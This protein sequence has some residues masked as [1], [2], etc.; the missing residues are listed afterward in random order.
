M[1]GARVC[2]CT[3]CVVVCVFVWRRYELSLAHADAVT[4]L[5][6]STTLPQRLRTIAANTLALTAFLESH[7]L[8]RTQPTALLHLMSVGSSAHLRNPS[9]VVRQVKTVHST[10]TPVSSRQA[11]PGVVPLISII[12]HKEEAAPHFYNALDVAKGPGFGT[13]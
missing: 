3:V 5:H 12:L 1:W 8:V 4:L 6:N 9:C 7:P 10:P 11:E 2:M 13:K